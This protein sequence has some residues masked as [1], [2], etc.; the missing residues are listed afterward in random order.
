MEALKTMCKKKK[1]STP[2]NLLNTFWP[3]NFD[4]EGD[5]TKMTQVALEETFGYKSHSSQAVIF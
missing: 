4:A 1:N 3:M 2:N 5:T